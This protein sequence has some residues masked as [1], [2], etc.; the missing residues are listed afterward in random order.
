MAASSSPAERGLSTAALCAAAGV[1]RGTLRLYEQEGLLMAPPRRANGYRCYATSEVQRL[2]A[3]RAFKELGFTLREIALLLE[4]RE[5]ARLGPERLQS[6]AAAQLR[7]IDQRI[8]R[9]GL[10][11]RY[12]AA[13][14]V[15]DYSALND[16]E[17]R[18][19]HEF[20]SL[21]AEPASAPPA[22]KASN[23]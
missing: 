15:G 8:A 12:L 1:T 13:V 16:P 5:A 4:E 10:V 17:C 19:L 22:A 6:L 11:R 2:H 18:F 20:L 14:A 21:Q 23:L 7:Q 3:I 9:L